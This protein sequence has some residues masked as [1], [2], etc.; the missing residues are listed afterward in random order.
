M[1]GYAILGI[2]SGNGKTSAAQVRPGKRIFFQ[3]LT[4][5]ITTQMLSYY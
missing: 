1:G 2:N 4:T 5:K 3:N